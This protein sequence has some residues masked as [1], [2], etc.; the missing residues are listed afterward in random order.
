MKTTNN[1]LN[2]VKEKIESIEPAPVE[3][4]VW[5][6]LKKKFRITNVKLTQRQKAV[7]LKTKN[8]NHE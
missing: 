4:S 3:I 7:L 2:Q 5:E 6:E 8:S 1:T